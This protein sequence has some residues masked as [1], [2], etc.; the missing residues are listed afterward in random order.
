[1]KKLLII[2]A[3]AAAFLAGCASSGGSQNGADVLQTGSHSGLKDQMEEQYHD[4]AAFQ[5]I[6]DKIY[7]DQSS[8]PA[9][10]NVDFTKNTVVV[11]GTGEMKHGGF[12]LRVDHAE[13]TANG[14]DV[15]FTVNQPGN[16]CPRT[17]TELTYPFIVATVPTTGHVDFDQVKTHQQ[18]DCT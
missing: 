1:M 16:N 10:P 14:Y 12:S 8:K 7:A 6:W 18:P 15:G 2:L 3:A 11:Y 17:T 13:P 5:A 9:L 4:Q